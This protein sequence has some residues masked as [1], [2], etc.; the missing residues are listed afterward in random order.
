MDTIIQWMEAAVQKRN[1]LLGTEYSISQIRSSDLQFEGQAMGS[2]ESLSV[3]STGDF[4]LTLPDQVP[5]DI[6]RIMVRVKELLTNPN[7]QNQYDQGELVQFLTGY[8]NVDLARTR[9]PEFSDIHFLNDVEVAIRGQV[10]QEPVKDF[11]ITSSDIKSQL[12][13]FIELLA[14]NANPEDEKV[15]IPLPFQATTQPSLPE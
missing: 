6:R 4:G 12:P 2:T 10:A 9:T 15:E 14:A 5:K 8:S 7:T 3:E 13:L 11:T 1:S